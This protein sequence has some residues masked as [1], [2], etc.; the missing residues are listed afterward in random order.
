MVN[1]VWLCG[2]VTYFLGNV[3]FFAALSFAPASLCAALLATVVV[4]NAIF[5]RAILKERLQRCDYHGAAL[6]GAGIALA[7][8]NAPYVTV[9]YDAEQVTHLWADAR[10][11]VYFSTL[12]VLIVALALLVHR[13]EALVAARS[14]A[15]KVMAE[16]RA[17][18]IDGIQVP[19]TRPCDT[20]PRALAEAAEGMCRAGATLMSAAS[21][22]GHDAAAEGAIEL[23]RPNGSSQQQPPLP[24][25]QPSHRAGSQPPCS[26]PASPPPEVGLRT[27]ATGAGG[28]F[29]GGNAAT[30]KES[31]LSQTMPFAYPVVLGSLETLVQMFQ[32]GASSMLYLTLTEGRSQLCHGAFWVLWL[33]LAVVSVLV[34][35]WL[36]KGLSHLEASRLL[37][38]E[39]GTVTS[40]SI[41]GG[42]VIYQEYRFVATHNLI[43]MMGGIILICL[44]CGLVG[45][46]KTIKKRF[47]PGY[48]FNHQVIPAAQQHL[49][50]HM[51]RL[52]GWGV[53]N[54]S[55]LDTLPDPELT[56]VSR[57]PTR[58][59]LGHPDPELTAVEAEVGEH[60]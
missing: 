38:I 11:V 54:Q 7:A 20:S 44:G 32:K 3:F 39:Y 50:R 29:G 1:A 43:N 36:R 58:S 19:R 46:R 25:Q 35:W 4:V 18:Y 45:R 22:K 34:I 6:I 55:I 37:P 13:H 40:T 31:W 47:D 60:V 24:Q 28:G 21:C 2:L 48:Q 57:M 27:P 56:T 59:G 12:F 14:K 30:N 23:Q 5:A 9:S 10:S 53:Y 15:T 17:T 42:L 16:Q 33:L 8:A 51:G 41:I 52:T 26:P 49:F